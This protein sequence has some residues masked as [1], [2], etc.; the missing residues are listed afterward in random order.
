MPV[1]LARVFIA[2]AEG[3]DAVREKLIQQ[4]RVARLAVEWNHM[5]SKLPWVP[6][7]KG[8]CR[9]RVFESSA[10]IV[11]LSKKA[12]AA[13][14]MKSE[15]GFLVEAQIPVLCVYTDAARPTLPA[16]LDS[17]PV[18]EWNWPAIAQFL[19]SVTAGTYG[20]GA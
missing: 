8:T 15:L 9:N 10:G 20:A 2:Y 17:A 3:D 18:V 12:V 19:Q 7:W 6:T 14:G 4:A 1:K 13:E 11:L 5:P 16:G